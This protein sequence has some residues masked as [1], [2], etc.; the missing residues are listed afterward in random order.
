MSR[1][2]TNSME[3]IKMYNIRVQTTID[4]WSKLYNIVL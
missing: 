3:L 2:V 4:S 1:D